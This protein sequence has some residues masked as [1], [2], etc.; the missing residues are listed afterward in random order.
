MRSRNQLSTSSSTQPAALAQSN[1]SREF[2]LFDQAV[3]LAAAQRCP[4]KDIRH[5]QHAHRI[6]QLSSPFL[7]TLFSERDA[8][9]EENSPLRLHQKLPHTLRALSWFLMGRRNTTTQICCWIIFRYED[10]L[11]HFGNL[12]AKAKNKKALE[13]Q[14]LRWLGD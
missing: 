13:N 2:V 8:V 5:A 12:A 14:G 10:A 11:R 6:V 7:V 4:F 9:S 1:L 3:D